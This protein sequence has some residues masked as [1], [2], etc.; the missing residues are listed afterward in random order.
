[1]HCQLALR[2]PSALQAQ[3]AQ[4]C[5]CCCSCCCLCRCATKLPFSEGCCR[6]CFQVRDRIMS[7]RIEPLHH[8]VF[9]YFGKGSSYVAIVVT[10]A[11]CTPSQLRVVGEQ[12]QL[13]QFPRASPPHAPA[14]SFKRGQRRRGRSRGRTR[15]TRARAASAMGSRGKWAAQA[16]SRWWSDS[17]F[18]CHT[19]PVQLIVVKLPFHR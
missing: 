19:I 5:S 8:F 13:S 4:R 11:F 15:A 17:R 16:T 12:R 3:L 9:R 18:L 6:C 1:M 7:R 10:A 2:Q 14:G